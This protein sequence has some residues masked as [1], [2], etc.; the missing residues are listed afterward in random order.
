MIGD[1]QAYK[2]SWKDWFIF[3]SAD[4]FGN[5]HFAQSLDDEYCAFYAP[6]STCPHS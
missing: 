6:P 3:A 2:H 1:K 4:N 5:W